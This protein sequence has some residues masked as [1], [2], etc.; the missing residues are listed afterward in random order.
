[1]KNEY[2][3]AVLT[4]RSMKLS[5]PMLTSSGLPTLPGYVFR[6][7]Q[8]LSDRQPDIETVIRVI[9]T[10]ASLTVQAL[11]LANLYRLE[12]DAAVTTVADAVAFL[13][14]ERLR[15][16]VLTCPVLDCASNVQLWVRLQSFWQHNFMTA[17][18]S[19]SIARFLDYEQPETAYTAGLLRNL[20][21]LSLIAR[22]NLDASAWPIA[23]IEEQAALRRAREAGRRLA[24]ACKLT[25]EMVEACG[26]EEPARAWHDLLLVKIVTAAS[27]F[28][29]S[30]GL[31][32]GD[33]PR[34]LMTNFDE[35]GTVGFLVT[36]LK[37]SC[38]R[39]GE[40]VAALCFTFRSLMG[41]LEFD[42]AGLLRAAFSDLAEE[43][44]EMLATA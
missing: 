25:R 33:T 30:N 31:V 2:T 39:A 15:T 44:I 42:N 7:N 32:S 18:L 24:I 38:Q 40:L 34:Q 5:T 19:E 41:S 3:K 35:K 9:R 22:C 20:G 6:L 36:H 17:V 12:Q 1:M 26:C 11:R 27:R 37:I 29:E 13:G 4:P 21:E 16:L 43:K 10:D 14:P 28:C 8:L 23:N